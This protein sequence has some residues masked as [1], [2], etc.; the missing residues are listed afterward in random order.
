MKNHIEITEEDIYK[1]VFNREA[2]SKN[3]QEYL[4]ANRERFSKEIALCVE[5]KESRAD[6]DDKL[7][8]D[9]IKS[10]QSTNIVE[11]YPQKPNPVEENGVKLAAS[12]VLVEKPTNSTSYMDSDS[13]Y[14]IRIIKTGSQ[15]LL[16]FFSNDATQRNFKL[17][18]IPSGN[19]YRVADTSQPIEILEEQVIEK[20]IVE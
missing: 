5:L 19:E 18:F 9:I 16:Y 14:L 8:S 7:V 10:I 1:F 12:S 3:K 2:L 17:K 4:E 13:K 6:M 11:L 20:I 15:T